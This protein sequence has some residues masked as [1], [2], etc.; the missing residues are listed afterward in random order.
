[1][2]TMPLRQ[3]AAVLLA[4][5]S[6]VLPQPADAS[7]TRIHGPNGLLTDGKLFV[8]FDAAFDSTNQVHLAVWGTQASGPTKGIFLNAS[9]TAITGADTRPPTTLG[10]APSIPATTT[11]AFAE[12]SVS[13]RR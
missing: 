12:C 3:V 8:K 4:A 6:V 11:I 5:T 10:S 2:R 13:V 7:L 9:G 1:M